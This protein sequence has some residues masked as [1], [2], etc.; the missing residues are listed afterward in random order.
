MKK[1]IITISIVCLFLLNDIGVSSSQNDDS[2]QTIEHKRYFSTPLYADQ[3]E[4]ISV[5]FHEA[6]SILSQAG[7][8]S[9]PIISEVFTLPFGS[10]INDITVTFGNE[11]QFLLPKKITPSISPQ[12]L[13]I[14]FN[15]ALLPS[16]LNTAVYE[17]SNPFPNEN[18]WYRTGTGLSGKDH[19]IYV[20]IFLSPLTYEPRRNIITK[21]EEA[22]ISISYDPPV[23]PMVFHDAYDLLIIAPRE[24]QEALQP[25]VEVKQNHEIRTILMVLEDIPSIGIDQQ[26]DIKYCIKDALETWGVTY[27]L[28]VGGGIKNYE[29]MPVRYAWVGS[30]DYERYFPSDLYYA[31]IYDANGNFSTWDNNSNRKYAEFPDDNVSVDLYPDVYLG[32][33]PCNTTE[34]VNHIVN[35]IISFMETN[36][37]THH[38]VQMGGDTFPGDSEKICEGEYA[39]KQVMERLPNYTS[40]QLWGS[41]KN[42]FRFT[43]VY[44]IFKG[45]DFVDFSGHGSYVSWAT[46]PPYDDSKWI[47]HGPYYDGF[48]YINAQ[49]LLNAKKLPVFVF[50]ACSCS[51]FSEFEPCLSWSVLKQPNGG[52]IASFGA[53]GI[54]YGM[55][56]S[57]ETERVFGWME[58]NLLDGLS[59]EKILGL[60]WG[61]SLTKYINSFVLDEADY[62][63]VYEME[64]F[65]DPSLA[66]DNA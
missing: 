16:D 18:Y 39:N 53:S 21:H 48:V 47:P 3:G 28:L 65:G 1:I 23:T 27:V 41:K 42:L 19:V 59:H 15:G 38:I 50:N 35:K 57:Y 22:T 4:F 31:D 9:L 2:N 29:Q 30:G 32:R 46:H 60:V 61:T 24:Y 43:I 8:P 64:L 51:K 7:N 11:Q 58:V 62:K 34:E 45:A 40:T 20:T 6:T 56:G 55:Y 49:W 63:T 26:E 25:L 12:Y 13:S 33:L 36:Q 52:G 66:I 17:G 14:E 54:G 37:V 5:T 44:N 10:T